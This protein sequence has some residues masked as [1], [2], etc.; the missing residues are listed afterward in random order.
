LETVSDERQGRRDL[1]KSESNMLPQLQKIRN[2]LYTDFDYGNHNNNRSDPRARN[3]PPQENNY[4]NFYPINKP[5]FQ[6]FD[7]LDNFKNAYDEINQ[8]AQTGLAKDTKKF[9]E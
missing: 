1:I 4:A 8:K 3:I 6:D 7:S 2:P 5:Q 9:S